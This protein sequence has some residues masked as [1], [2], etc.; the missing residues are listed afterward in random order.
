V[1]KPD[2]LEFTAASKGFDL[3]DSALRRHFRH[4]ERDRYFML[5]DGGDGSAEPVETPFDGLLTG[6]ISE[7]QVAETLVRSVLLRLQELERQQRPVRD[8]PSRERLA[9]YL[10]TLAALERGLKRLEDIRKP[11]AATLTLL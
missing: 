7:K 8:Q 4:V 3:S 1:R 5:S 6:W 9:R 2:T 10:K 11:V